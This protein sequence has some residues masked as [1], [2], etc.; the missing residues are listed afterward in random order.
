MARIDQLLIY[1]KE[2]GGS[3]LHLAAGLEPRVRVKGRLRS[4]EGQAVLTDESLRDLTREIATDADW[5]DYLACGD[6][7]FAYGLEGV[8]RFR[9][10]YFLQ[11][12]GA[13]AVFRIIPEEILTLDDLKLPASVETVTS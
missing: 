11:E 6:L 12:H 3:D 9:A 4:V 1:L 13:G 8:A 5:Q 7:D 2:N 10:N